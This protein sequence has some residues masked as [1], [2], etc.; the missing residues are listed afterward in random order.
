MKDSQL[1]PRVELPNLTEDEQEQID[2]FKEYSAW[3][4]RTRNAFLTALMAK[5]VPFTGV[6]KPERKPTKHQRHK[7]RVQVRSEFLQEARSNA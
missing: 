5:C 3:R 4:T 2:S 7:A 6:A 1:I